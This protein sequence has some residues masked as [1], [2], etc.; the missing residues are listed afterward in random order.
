VSAQLTLA[1]GRRDRSRVA[2]HGGR[3]RV[4]FPC[5]NGAGQAPTTVQLYHSDGGEAG[6]IV[7]G[8]DASAHLTRSSRQFRAQIAPLICDPQAFCDWSRLT[9]HGEYSYFVMRVLMCRAMLD[10][11]RRTEQRSG[12][13]SFVA[14]PVLPLTRSLRCSR[15]EPQ[16]ERVGPDAHPTHWPATVIVFVPCPS[17]R[18]LSV[19]RLRA[20]RDRRVW[21]YSRRQRNSR[22]LRRQ[23]L[24]ASHSRRTMRRNVYAW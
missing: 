17:F 18:S 12:R 21:S 3:I 23:L 4:S 20:V 19:P 1:R 2:G 5:C 9:P 16:Q 11:R 13:S 6:L 10:A 14:V 15:G 22:L 8:A 7:G 24:R